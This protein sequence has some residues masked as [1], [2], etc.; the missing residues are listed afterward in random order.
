MLTCQ[1]TKRKN[2]ASLRRFVFQTMS[3][4]LF[5]KLKARAA[6]FLWVSALCRTRPIRAAEEICS[7]SLLVWHEARSCKSS[8]HILWC[9]FVRR[10][11]L[12]VRQSVTG[13]WW[14]QFCP[15][16]AGSMCP[17][18]SARAPAAVKRVP[19]ELQLSVCL[20][21]D[22]LFVSNWSGAVCSGDR[23]DQCDISSA[24]LRSQLHNAFWVF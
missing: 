22:L 11:S 4:V 19:A 10:S 21:T 17:S 16:Q 23:F 24:G 20:S 3:Q 18:A 13:R 5:L 9:Y 2:K 14:I 6:D 1:E 7:D 15:R 12:Q 8:R